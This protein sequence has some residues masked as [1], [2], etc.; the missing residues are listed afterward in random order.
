MDA[1]DILIFRYGFK[2]SEIEPMT[3]AQIFHYLD[4]AGIFAQKEAIRRKKR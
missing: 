1:A 4:R 3:D 2:P